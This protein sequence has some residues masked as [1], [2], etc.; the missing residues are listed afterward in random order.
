MFQGQDVEKMEAIVDAITGQVLSFEDTVDYLQAVGDVFPFSNDQIDERG[1]LQDAWPMPF[2]S[3]GSATTDSGG[4]YALAG[5]QTAMLTGPYVEMRDRKSN[6]L[7]S[8]GSCTS[9]HLLLNRS[10]LF[11]SVCGTGY[12]S[13]VTY[14]IAE[15]TQS[16]G[17]DWGGMSVSTATDC[18]T[19]GFGTASNTHSS[20]SGF[21][22][23]RKLELSKSVLYSYVLYT[24]LT[25]FSLT[26]C[27]AQPNYRDCT[28]PLA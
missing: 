28:K 19:P 17:I 16:N 14:G 20:R 11:I 10:M 27:P 24:L 9:L 13:H 5:S 21:Y 8:I 26:S 3:V 1:S 2:M 6:F 22:E 23:V 25:Y 18:S 12:T 4:N 15:L 7:H